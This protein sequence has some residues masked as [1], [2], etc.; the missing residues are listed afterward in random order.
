MSHFFWFMTSNPIHTITNIHA[1]THINTC[2]LA[3]KYEEAVFIITSS[4]IT[5]ISKMRYFFRF[6]T[7]IIRNSKQQKFNTHC[8]RQEEE[9]TKSPY[10]DLKSSPVRQFK[11]RMVCIKSTFTNNPRSTGPSQFR[12][13][14][15]NMNITH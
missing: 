12:P 14:S 13:Y 1:Q 9:K 8:C 11:K 6:I 10:L 3:C 2:S 7:I 15:F 5:W 4:Y